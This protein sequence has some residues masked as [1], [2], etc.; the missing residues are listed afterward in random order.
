MGKSI[1]WAAALAA[2][3]IFAVPAA[4]APDTG[5]SADRS[6]PA[7]PTTPLPFFRRSEPFPGLPGSAGGLPSDRPVLGTDGGLD[8]PV[9]PRGAEPDATP[10]APSPKP[11][12]HAEMLDKLLNR[13]ALA[14]DSDEAKGIAGLVERL[15]M[16]S[17]SDTADL[18]MTRAVAAMDGERRDVAAALLDKIIDL[19][20]GWA[21]A[22]NKRATLRFLDDDDSGAMEDISH[23]LVLEP[24]HFGALSGM[25]FILERHGDHAA[26]LK[27]L[28]RALA[29][30]PQDVEIQKAVDKLV[31]TV[32]GESL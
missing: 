8:S 30:D 16:Q 22:W 14:H 31:P 24:R 3:T 19:Q 9:P 17:G 10:A 21:E 13:L 6:E 12:S 7:T 1:A 29:V 2:L 20:P 32:D 4:G 28:R 5:G 23:V 25:G 15:W 27:V 18:L 26:A 11:P